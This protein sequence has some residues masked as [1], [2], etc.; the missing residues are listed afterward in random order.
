MTAS[1]DSPRAT[2][3]PERRLEG[4]RDLHPPSAAKKEKNG[5]RGRRNSLKRLNSAKGKPRISFDH[6]WPG[7]AQFFGIWLNLDLAWIWL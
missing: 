5:P 4:A 3:G 1:I 2:R 6:L 7:L